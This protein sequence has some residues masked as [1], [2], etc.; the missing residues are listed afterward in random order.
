MYVHIIYIYVCEV[1][2]IF[3]ANMLHGKVIINFIVRS[4][5]C[6]SHYLHHDFI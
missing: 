6:F 1:I 5:K 3:D 4:F 2:P